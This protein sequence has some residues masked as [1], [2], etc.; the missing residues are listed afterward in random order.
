MTTRTVAARGLVAVVLLLTL[1]TNVPGEA[2][3]VLPAGT[4]PN[5]VRLKPLKDLD[6]YFPFT[7]PTS[8][9]TR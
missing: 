1:A 6:G 8:A 5:D 7:P 2:P 4:L 9:R 3:R